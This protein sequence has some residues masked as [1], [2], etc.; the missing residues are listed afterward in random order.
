MTILWTMLAT[1]GYLI[2]GFSL[3]PFAIVILRPL[4]RVVNAIMS[5]PAAKRSELTVESHMAVGMVFYTLVTVIILL[6]GLAYVTTT[7]LDVYGWPIWVA[8]VLL[9]IMNYSNATSRPMNVFKADEAVALGKIAD[10]KQ[11]YESALVRASSEDEKTLIKAEFDK[12][13]VLAVQDARPTWRWH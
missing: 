7:M 5:G 11:W 1:I 13:C 3:V 8:A 9:I 12:K 6:L 10:A 4:I 2:V